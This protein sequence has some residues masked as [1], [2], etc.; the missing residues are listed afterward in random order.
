MKKTDVMHPR[1]L[2]RKQSSR[3]DINNISLEE[4]NQAVNPPHREHHSNNGDVIRDVIIGFADGL[5]VP[6]ALTAGLSSS[7]FTGALTHAKGTNLLAMKSR[8]I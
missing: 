1:R 6:F 5:T 8:L 4:Q 7:V 2:F 3:A